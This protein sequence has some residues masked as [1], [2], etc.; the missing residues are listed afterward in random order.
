MKETH[1]YELTPSNGST[2]I[3]LY[4]VPLDSFGWY[5]EASIKI[6]CSISSSSQSFAHGL[7]GRFTLRL[8]RSDLWLLREYSCKFVKPDR[9]ESGWKSCCTQSFVESFISCFQSS[10]SI[11]FWT[12]LWW[13]CG[14][15]V[16]IYPREFS[17]MIVHLFS[18]YSC[19][20]KKIVRL[21]DSF[22]LD[23]VG[24]WTLDDP[25]QQ[26]FGKSIE[27]CS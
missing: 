8:E 10:I 16:R 26:Q 9:T 5:I 11:V 24:K 19:E 22:W 20:K 2:E 13:W 1:Y 4:R 18:F 15:D 21:D 17:F 12:I 27:F 25:N 7:T 14:N 23:S 3:P 6:A